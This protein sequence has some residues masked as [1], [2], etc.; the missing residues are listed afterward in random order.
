MGV[1]YWG[2]GQAEG[3]K[4]SAGL[5]QMVLVP[6]LEWDEPSPREWGKLVSLGKRL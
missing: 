1:E 4:P 3:M 5:H 2:R 6:V